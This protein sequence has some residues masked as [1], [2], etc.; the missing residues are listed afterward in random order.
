MHAV[1][2]TR[3]EE[4]VA[5]L[6]RQ[7][8]SK[9]DF[10]GDL[11]SMD[12]VRP[13]YTGLNLVPR[14]GHKYMNEFLDEG[15]I[16][17]PIKTLKQLGK[18]LDVDI[19]P[20]FLE[21]LVLGQ[22]DVAR[23]LVGNL[24]AVT[25]KSVLVRMLDGNVRAVLSDRYRVMDN[26][27][28]AFSALATVRENGGEI[29]KSY[30]TDDRMEI[31]FTT[32]ELWEK[33]NSVAKHGGGAHQFIEAIGKGEDGGGTGTDPT[34]N[35]VITIGNSEVGRGGQFVRYG[36]LARYCLNTMMI[37]TASVER[38]LGSRMESGI[39]TQE[40]L[41][42][43]AKALQLKVRD[44][45]VA[46]FHPATFA[47]ICKKVQGAT[48]T[49]I[50]NPTTAVQ[51]VVEGNQLSEQAKDS[52]LEYFLKDYDSTAYGLSA[53]VSRYAQDVDADVGSDLEVLAGAIVTNPKQYATA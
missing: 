34:F 47:R 48:E 35:P 37:E 16:N 32:K 13:D 9:V 14:Q 25:E 50:E 23:D 24:M 49:V 41:D 7:K 42:A 5:E 36:I 22:P 53:A 8:K 39:L 12:V 15:G 11:R 43:D 31:S 26:Y 21:N 17:V 18:R 19:P 38:H 27:D 40:T 33:F 29:L 45:I 4:L 20:A 44:M 30:L 2:H 52:I 46:G 1:K 6:D 51:N 28:L 3:L 10:V